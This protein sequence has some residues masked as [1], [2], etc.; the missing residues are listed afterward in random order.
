MR[1]KNFLSTGQYGSINRRY[2]TKKLSSYID[3][4]IDSTAAGGEV[5]T[6]YLDFVMTSQKKLYTIRILPRLTIK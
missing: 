6:I 3:N 2:I 5:N 1:G 4:C